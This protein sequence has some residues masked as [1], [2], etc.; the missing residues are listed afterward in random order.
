MTKLTSK[1]KQDEISRKMGSINERNKLMKEGRLTLIQRHKLMTDITNLKE[2]INDSLSKSDKKEIA[3]SHN[4]V[5]TK[6]KQFPST[7][8]KTYQFDP[9]LN[10]LNKVSPERKQQT[11]SSQTRYRP[12]PV[13]SMEKK[14]ELYSSKEVTPTQENALT[15]RL[16]HLNPNARKVE[17]HKEK[18]R[19]KQL[20]KVALAKNTRIERDKKTIKDFKTE[21]KYVPHERIESQTRLTPDSSPI[22]VRV[23][24]KRKFT[25]ILSAKESDD[26]RRE[27]DVKLVKADVDVI[28]PRREEST[29]LVEKRRLAE[30]N[31]KSTLRVPSPSAKGHSISSTN[32]AHNQLVH[33]KIMLSIRK[34][35]LDKSNIALQEHKD[36]KLSHKKVRRL[37]KKNIKLTNTVAGLTKDVKELSPLTEKEET[38]PQTRTP[39]QTLKDIL[40]QSKENPEL[41][42]QLKEELKK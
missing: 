8:K 40:S 23:P 39:T 6:R 41:V 27:R 30:L 42:K 12:T 15:E 14:Y 10:T 28:I 16:K 32:M 7:E 11:P 21:E 26:L 24:A 17:L 22:L 29:K 1:R 38:T 25:K 35:D 20:R 5:P 2:V 18:Q 33:K 3:S 37:V 13:K 19:I 9:S 4:L 31:A 36:D 34:E